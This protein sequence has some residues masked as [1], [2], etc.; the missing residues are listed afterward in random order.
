MYTLPVY[1]G[2]IFIGSKD[3]KKKL[4]NTFYTIL[5]IYYLY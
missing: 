1:Q 5:E 2:I 4:S 3:N